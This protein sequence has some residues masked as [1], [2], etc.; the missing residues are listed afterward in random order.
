MAADT[1]SRTAGLRT[2]R[3]TLCLTGPESTGKTTLA[4]A[5]AGHFDVPLVPEIAREYLSRRE[6]Y[7]AQDLLEIVRQQ[8]DAEASMRARHDGLLICD[9]DLL[10]LQI[11]WSEKFG[12]LPELISQAMAQ[13]TP[14][15]YLLMYPDLPWEADAQRENPYDRLRLFARH[16][17]EL[18][19][20]PYRYG[21][22]EGLGDA[23]L[24]AALHQFERLLGG[25]PI[26]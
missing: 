21:I 7:D 13:R 9:T 17:S 11:W 24:D 5:L 20:G 25:P 4:E 23:R 22:V 2:G 6:T 10:V 3:L 15:I 16:E 18:T 12:P 14:R 26:V 1:A 19:L 8:I